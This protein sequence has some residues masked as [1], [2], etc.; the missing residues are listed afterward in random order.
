MKKYS[1]EFSLYGGLKIIPV[2]ANSKEE[3]VEKAKKEYEFLPLH[4]IECVECQ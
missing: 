1:V 3:A 4:F 2:E